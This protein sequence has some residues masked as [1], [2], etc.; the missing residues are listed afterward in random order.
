MGRKR[1]MAPLSK[2]RVARMIL[3]DHRDNREGGSARRASG[4]DRGEGG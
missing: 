1:K 3:K 4:S 2:K